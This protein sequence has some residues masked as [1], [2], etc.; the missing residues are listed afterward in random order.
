MFAERFPSKRIKEL[1][2][3][4]KINYRTAPSPYGLVGQRQKSFLMHTF[5]LAVFSIS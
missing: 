4:N 3:G 1:S 5:A 2:R